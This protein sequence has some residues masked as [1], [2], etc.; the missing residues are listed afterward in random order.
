M[1]HLNLIL[2]LVSGLLILKVP[3]CYSTVQ[4]LL[5]VYI[6]FQH[7][8]SRS[9]S[10]L[11][12]AQSSRTKQ[13]GLCAPNAQWAQLR[14]AGT[15]ISREAQT[16]VQGWVGLIL[17]LKALTLL[18]YKDT[19]RS[20]RSYCCL[21]KHSYFDLPTKMFGCGRSCRAYLSRCGRLSGVCLGRGKGERQP[22]SR[23]PF[24]PD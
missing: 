1:V 24:G 21:K 20:Q 11:G 5:W 2:N 22:G 3:W 23:S 8:P 17:V 9:V 7:A 15:L 10:Q 19:H 14:P 4:C 6:S 16:A 12:S 13:T 18:A